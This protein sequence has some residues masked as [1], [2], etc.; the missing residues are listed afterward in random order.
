MGRRIGKCVVHVIKR[1][2]VKLTQVPLRNATH[3]TELE[4]GH[5]ANMKRQPGSSVTQGS[6]HHSLPLPNLT[7]H[8]VIRSADEPSFHTVYFPLDPLVLRLHLSE[9][10]HQEALLNLHVGFGLL[11]GRDLCQELGPVRGKASD[12]VW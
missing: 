10:V 5:I 9:L 3:D 7:T 6:M 11:Q 4:P 2:R 8:I 12:R 1:R